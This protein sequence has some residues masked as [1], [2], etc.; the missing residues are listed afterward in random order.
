[1]NAGGDIIPD[2]VASHDDANASMLNVELPGSNADGSEYIL[3]H[4]QRKYKFALTTKD[5]LCNIAIVMN[6]GGLEGL[7]VFPLDSCGKSVRYALEGTPKWPPTLVQFQTEPPFWESKTHTL[8]IISHCGQRKSGCGTIVH[9]ICHPEAA[10]YCEYVIFEATLSTTACNHSKNAE[11]HIPRHINSELARTIAPRNA[12]L[13]TNNNNQNLKTN[14]A[15]IAMYTRDQ[16]KQMQHRYRLSLRRDDDLLLSIAKL[17]RDDRQKYNS[18]RKLQTWMKGNIH[19]LMENIGINAVICNHKCM[20]F[21][22]NFLLFLCA[23]V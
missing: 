2:V 21:G 13:I 17:K 15:Q 3:M 7:F 10:L 19:G 9:A 4:P 11:L 16:I 8:N 1:M 5:F 12:P 6:V 22:V 18:N 14:I 20:L 23:L